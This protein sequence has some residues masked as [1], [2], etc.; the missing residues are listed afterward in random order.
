M[1]LDRKRI[2]QKHNPKIRGVEWLSPLSIGNSE[3][4]FSVD[5]TGLQS[6]PGLYDTPLGTQS[7]WGWHSTGGK[8]RFTVADMEYQEFDHYGH[9]V[10]Y[11]MKPEKHAEAYHWHRQNPHRIQLGQLGFEF[12]DDQD[13]PIAAKD[14]H[15]INQE[16]DLWSGIITSS[17]V[18]HDHRVEVKTICASHTD[19][20]GVQITS[21]LL[22]EGKVKVKLAFPSPDV[23]DNNWS[24]AT[25]LTWDNP[26]R[27]Q[28]EELLHSKDR[29]VLQ[30]VMDDEDYFV[31]WQKNGGDCERVEPHLFQVTPPRSQETY[32][33]AVTFHSKETAE[34]LSFDEIAEQSAGYWADFWESGAFVSFEGSSDQR[35]MEL[36]RR[37]ILSQYLTAIHSSGSIP[38]QETGLMYNSWFGKAHLEM[39]WWHAAHF[40]LWG[41]AERLDRSLSWYQHILPIAKDIASQQGYLGARWPKM[42]GVDGK[43]SPS[44]VAPG[45]IWQQPHPI[46]LAEL[47]YRADRDP[48]ILE[49]YKEIVFQTATFMADFAVWDSEQACYVLGPPLIPAQECHRMED[50]INPPYEVEYWKYGLETALAW[51]N[52]LGVTVEEKWLEVANHLQK[53]RELDGIYLAHQDCEDTF[54]EK[55]HDHPSMVAAYGILPGTMIN[56]EWMRNTLMKVKEEWQWETAWGW[57]FPMCAMTAARLGESE[58]AVDFLLLDAIKNTHLTNGHNYQR[59]G[60]TAY[61][62]GNGG[63]LIAIAMMVAGWDGAGNK[64]YPGFPDNGQ[65]KVEAEGFLPYI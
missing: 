36:E 46:M 27:H 26:D 6:F 62:P 64:D 60:L 30:R 52:R 15:N 17:Y 31:H 19:T 42:V 54:T 11:P 38:P 8:Q 4:G 53:P 32:S 44:P 16:L 63:L 47:L 7:N 13:Q 21:T 61:L 29:V 5:F 9:K 50:S 23:V 45:L 28:T 58:L 43:Q 57:D 25:K 33:F 18:I 39:H 34:M 41:R 20:I 49:K 12:L 51:A 2:V 22:S 55:N 59:K 37:V 35:A 48:A 24:K 3:L 10:P 65:W 56:K 14:I 40:P 1:N